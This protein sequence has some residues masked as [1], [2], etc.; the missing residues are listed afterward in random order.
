MPQQ[1]KPEFRSPVSEEPFPHP[2][3]EETPKS[4]MLEPFI[5]L[6]KHR[7]LIL[8]TVAAAAI[9]S[10]VI[11]LLL[12]KAY[13]ANARI[14]PPQ[15]S[16]SIASA[17]LGQLGP[18]LG[19]A[20]GKDLGLR[21]PNDM[22]V[23]ML[24]SRTV[25]D[26]MIDRFSL[27]KV[28]GAKMYVDARHKLDSE[29]EINVGHDNVIS[30]SV[31]DR[32]PQRATDMANAYVDELGKLTRTLAVTEAGKRRLFFEQEMKTA[33]DELALAEDALKKTEENTGII[34]LDSQAKGML[35]A[36]EEL[37][38]RVS[39]KEVEI[40][41]MK[42]FATKD[43]PDLIR[44][45]QELEA[46][47]V[48]VARFE[49][50]RG[51]AS[52]SSPSNVSLAKVP[53]VGLEYVRKMRA[54]KYRETLYELLTKQYEIARIDEAKEAAIIQVLDKAVVPEKRSWPPRAALVL[55]STL[56]ALMVIIPVVF[57]IEWGKKSSQ[58]PQFTAHWD[59]LKFYLRGQHSR[60]K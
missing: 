1:E 50:G 43:N 57:L 9:V 51:G 36:Y 5:V 30:I 20:A 31:E 42:S 25:S 4:H 46:L 41:G 32:D 17:M 16:S 2:I 58:D 39:V 52:G 49:N 19:A 8:W 28:Y 40:Q 26:R 54:V 45:E 53:G 60:A 35:Q 33:S 47:R 48:Q 37:R 27:L 15:E 24:H 7:N 21:N 3:Y 10:A 18:L 44:A 34:Q 56:L 12:P 6:A 14:L 13:T 11:S 38:A 55:V 22:Y 59:L 29:V 23:A